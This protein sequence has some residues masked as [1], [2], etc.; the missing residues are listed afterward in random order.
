MQLSK[1]LIP[2][3]ITFLGESLYVKFQSDNRNNGRGFSAYYL[4]SKTTDL[5]PKPT[6][7]PSMQRWVLE[8]QK[9]Q[10][11]KGGSS[12]GGNIPSVGGGAPAKKTKKN[13]KKKTKFQRTRLWDISERD[14]L[15]A[16]RIHEENKSKVK[17]W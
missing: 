3:N 6:L 8:N 13:K 10:P 15:K 9:H 16:E 2:K 1:E 11:S 17:Y 7:S 4:A 5:R 14:V 12:V